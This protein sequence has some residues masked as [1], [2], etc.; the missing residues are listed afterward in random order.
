MTKADELMAKLK[1]QE[2]KADDG[3]GLPKTKIGEYQ[4]GMIRK[5]K[6]LERSSDLSNS[7]EF[8]P[9]P[10][11]KSFGLDQIESICR[12]QIKDC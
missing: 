11:D 8:N 12:R 6:K 5:L 9:F 2:D 4:T 7:G 3:D 1:V 10:N